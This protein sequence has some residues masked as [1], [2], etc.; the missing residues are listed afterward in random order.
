MSK[1]PLSSASQYY[2]Q[3]SPYA[4]QAHSS[5]TYN[6]ENQESLHPSGYNVTG[7]YSLE[8]SSGVKDQ[9]FDQ[10]LN[11]H[12][13]EYSN[14]YGSF[15]NSHPSY[16]DTTHQH[17]H[18]YQP[19]HHHQQHHLSYNS[20]SSSQYPSDPQISGRFQHCQNF[21]DFSGFPN[22]GPNFSPNPYGSPR[23][24]PYCPNPG[25]F[26]RVGH[27]QSDQPSCSRGLHPTFARRPVP[28]PK[29]ASFPESSQVLDILQC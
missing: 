4:V 18:R 21:S 11:P 6:L 9:S 13:S 19:Y 26:D 7:A 2:H 22:S 23:K 14:I 8:T 15:E 3:Q 29:Y 5:H 27:F 16:C 28:I 1:W 12:Q 17:L 20:T 25:F 10:A 24:P